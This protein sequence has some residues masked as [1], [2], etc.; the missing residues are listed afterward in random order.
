MQH[1]VKEGEDVHGAGTCSYN[2]Q[3]VV[4]EGEEGPQTHLLLCSLQ[5][6]GELV[7]LLGP[8]L[9]KQ[10]AHKLSGGTDGNGLGLA[11]QNLRDFVIKC[12]FA[13]KSCS[14]FYIC[15]ETYICMCC[16][17]QRTISA[18]MS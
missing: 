8:R 3:L 6:Q 16:C 18:V 14:K 7:G 11:Q 4:K 2:M 12:I 1:V 17:K 9:W 13:I 15:N 5:L 10:Q